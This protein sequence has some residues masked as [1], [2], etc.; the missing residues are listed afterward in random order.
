MHFWHEPQ[1]GNTVSFS[2][3]YISHRIYI[4]PITKNVNLD[5]LAK[6]V[7]TGV[8]LLFFTLKLIRI[9]G[10]DTLRQGRYFVPH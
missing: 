8:K 5:P 3:H 9:W 6:V 1:S 10:E 4:L 7:S 2:L